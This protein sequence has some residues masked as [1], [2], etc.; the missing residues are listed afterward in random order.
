MKLQSLPN[1]KRPDLYSAEKGQQHGQAMKTH[2]AVNRAYQ[3]VAP[4]L[5]SLDGSE[6]DYNPNPGEVV[7]VDRYLSTGPDTAVKVQAAELN[8][9]A[10]TGEVDRFKVIKEDNS[11]V[12]YEHEIYDEYR[13]PN[14][15]FEQVKGDDSVKFEMNPNT[16]LVV[17]FKSK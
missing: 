7:V 12:S 8:F 13:S 9:D 5:A 3:D 10:A 16:G 11:S 15:S 6:Y 2:Q 14:P 17:G 4:E 1:L